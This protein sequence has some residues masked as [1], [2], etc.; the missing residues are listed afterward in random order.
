MSVTRC[1][2]GR[3]LSSRHKLKPAIVSPLRRMLTGDP[4]SLPGLVPRGF[5]MSGLVKLHHSEKIEEE[6]LPLY[7]AENYYP[8]QIGEIFA[9]L[10][11]VISKLGYGTTSTTWLC[12]D[13]Q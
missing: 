13:L 7:I 3:I 12:R 10:Y 11:Q 1:S 8:T 5:P 9:S 6:D 2:L 4:A